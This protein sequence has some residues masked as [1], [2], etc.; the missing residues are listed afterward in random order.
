MVNGEMMGRRC[1]QGDFPLLFKG[2]GGPLNPSGFHS[3]QRCA[4]S[5]SS[6]FL[7]HDSTLVHRANK[8]EDGI[9]HR[10]KVETLKRKKQLQV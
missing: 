4:M 1:R 10:Y 6:F 2:E 5:Q 7:V 8:R 3:S 9:H